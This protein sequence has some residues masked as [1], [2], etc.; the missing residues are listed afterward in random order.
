MP[1]PQ[2]HTNNTS[3][4]ANRNTKWTISERLLLSVSENDESSRPKIERLEK[5]PTGSI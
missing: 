5:I 3:K 2:T 1:L 4:K